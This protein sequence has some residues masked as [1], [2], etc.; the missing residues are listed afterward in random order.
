M[1]L[2]KDELR[3]QDAAKLE[4]LISQLMV[5]RRADNTEDLDRAFAALVDFRSRTPFPKLQTQA[6]KA[7][8]A[9]AEEVSATAL[10]ELADIAE[11][12]SSAGAGFKA[13][14]MIAESGKKDLLFPTLAGTAARG[15]ELVK[16]L[17]EAVESVKANLE[18]VDELG[19]VPQAVDDL[20]DAF[21][22]LK[23]KLEAAEG[24]A[25]SSAAAVAN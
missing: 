25:G 10:K 9:A 15:L 6:A 17:K 3:A 12:V 21:N 8:L 16:Q 22:S 14:A 7:R 24:G 5:A 13:A 23:E 20:F 19:D 18:N 11:R 1:A 2:T 4:S